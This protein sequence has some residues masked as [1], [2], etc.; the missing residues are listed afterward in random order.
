MN[1]IAHIIIYAFILFLT[2]SCS[3]SIKSNFN[4][5][6]Y[7]NFKI[8]R[9]DKSTTNI[10]KNASEL[11]PKIEELKKNCSTTYPTKS[12]NTLIPTDSIGGKGCDSIILKNGNYILATVSDE[13]NS[14]IFYSDC[15]SGNYLLKKIKKTEIDSIIFNQTANQSNNIPS[16]DSNKE[17]STYLKKNKSTGEMAAIVLLTL[18]V[19]LGGLGIFASILSF[20][21]GAGPVGI[22]VLVISILL[23]IFCVAGLSK[24]I[25]K[26]NEIP[27]DSIY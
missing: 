18:G 22:A 6:K 8:R 21:F 1:K 19:V 7:T 13:N 5:Q 17:T 20:A 9:N 3:I 14:K 16:E 12:S 27:Y 2:H 10:E 11:I 24:R 23:I 4:T 15:N 26:K 25:K